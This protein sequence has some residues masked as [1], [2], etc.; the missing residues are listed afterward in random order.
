MGQGKINGFN[1]F[2]INVA[3]NPKNQLNQAKYRKFIC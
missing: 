3:I 1:L 2:I